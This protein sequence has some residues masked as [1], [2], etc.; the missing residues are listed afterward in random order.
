MFNTILA[1]WWWKSGKASRRKGLLNWATSDDSGSMRPGL[2]SGMKK[3]AMENHEDSASPWRNLK[4]DW[5]AGIQKEAE[6]IRDNRGQKRPEQTGFYWPRGRFQLGPKSNG[7]PL[8]G[9]KQGTKWSDFFHFHSNSLFIHSFNKYLLNK[10]MKKGST[11]LVIR[12]M[13]VKPQ[14]NTITQPPEWLKWK[15]QVWAKMQSNWNSPSMSGS[16]NWFNHFGKPF[17]NFC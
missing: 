5:V 14:Q 17:G 11:S 1:S 2:C 4:T 15:H 12:A 8:V 9:I 16:V 13:Q 7:E 6:R 10:H 3:T